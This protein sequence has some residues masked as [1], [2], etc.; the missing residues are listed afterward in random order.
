MSQ[1]FVEAV[2]LATGYPH[3][4]PRFECDFYMWGKLKQKAYRDSLH[5][6]GALQNEIRN[7]ICNITEGELQ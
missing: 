3:L 6:L 7:V 2:I 5:G 4:F 1:H